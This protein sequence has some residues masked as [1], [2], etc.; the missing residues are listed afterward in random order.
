MVY[1]FALTQ[2]KHI[3][4]RLSGLMVRPPL[5]HVSKQ[6]RAEAS[7]PYYRENKFSIPL[8]ERHCGPMMF[9]LIAGN[10]FLHVREIWIDFDYS[11]ELCEDLFQFDDDP[12]APIRDMSYSDMDRVE[13]EAR[14]AADH[15]MQVVKSLVAAGFPKSRLQCWVAR[16][17]WAEGNPIEGDVTR[18]MLDTI[19]RFLGMSGEETSGAE[20]ESVPVLEDWLRVIKTHRANLKAKAEERVS[21]LRGE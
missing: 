14:E 20:M 16:S 8:D 9:A 6:I 15:C 7:G 11:E 3:N 1:E 18:T 2:E 10:H 13:A 4:I 21:D 12:L 5:L 19:G 17:W